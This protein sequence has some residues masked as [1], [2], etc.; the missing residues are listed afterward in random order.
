MDR[1]TW[2]FYLFSKWTVYYYLSIQFWLKFDWRVRWKLRLAVD[3]FVKTSV[4]YGGKTSSTTRC[5]EWISH[6]IWR[7]EKK[8]C[9]FVIYLIFFTIATLTIGLLNELRVLL[10]LYQVINQL[11]CHADLLLFFV[12]LYIYL[13]IELMNRLNKWKGTLSLYYL[14]VWMCFS[15]RN[16]WWISEY[17]SFVDLAINKRH[18]TVSLHLDCDDLVEAVLAFFYK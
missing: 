3:C 12:A 6:G 9:K 8:N 1:V 5:R 10:L 11:L 16:A 13:F 17:H 4:C 2:H 18:L 15:S 14:L 7:P